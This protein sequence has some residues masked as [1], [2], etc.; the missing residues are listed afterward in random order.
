LKIAYLGIHGKTETVKQQFAEANNQSLE[1]LVK[2]GIKLQFL[3]FLPLRTP[4]KCSVPKDLIL[5]NRK[6]RLSITQAGFFHR[7]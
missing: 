2:K 4:K 1:P 7:K 6:E 5:E 3:I